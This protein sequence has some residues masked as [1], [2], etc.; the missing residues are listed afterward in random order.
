MKSIKIEHYLFD[1]IDILNKKEGF[2]CMVW[3][4][5]WR[6]D[7]CF[8]GFLFWFFSFL[9][10]FFWFGASWSAKQALI[11]RFHAHSAAA[12][13]SVLAHLVLRIAFANW[14]FLV[15]TGGKNRLGKLFHTIRALG[16]ITFGHVTFWGATYN[17]KR[18]EL[19]AKIV[20]N[21][22]KSLIQHC[23][24]RSELRLHVEWTK[25]D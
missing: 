19:G 23:C 10:F 24:E 4:Y 5:K 12:K 18:F 21:H 13:K 20:Q 11:L 14:A 8:N 22:G 2:C 7:W 17:K 16:L 15:A 1:S 25:V 3:L 6:N 9:F